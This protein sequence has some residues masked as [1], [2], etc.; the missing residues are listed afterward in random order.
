MA[1]RAKVHDASKLEEHEKSGYDVCTI[2]LKNIPYGTPEYK[3]ALEELKPTLEHHYAANSHH[4]EHYENG[5]AG[6]DIFDLIEMIMDWKAATERMK[7]GGDIE[8]SIAYN[9]D[10][11]KIDPQLVSIMENTVKSMGWKKNA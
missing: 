11:F 6:M 3:A 1:H 2:R 10:R 9:K 8:K 7:D 5:I 4:P